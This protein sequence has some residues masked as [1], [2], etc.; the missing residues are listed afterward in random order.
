MTFQLYFHNCLSTSLWL[1]IPHH[2]E[3]SR[4]ALAVQHTD[5]AGRL[6]C[7][8][9]GETLYSSVSRAGIFYGTIE[10]VSKSGVLKPA[11]GLMKQRFWA[12]RQKDVCRWGGNNRYNRE[13][14]PLSHSV[15]VCLA[16]E[17]GSVHSDLHTPQLWPPAPGAAPAPSKREASLAAPRWLSQERCHCACADPEAAGRHH[18]GHVSPMPGGRSASLWTADVVTAVSV[19]R[20]P[21]SLL[22]WLFTP[23]FLLVL[24][25]Y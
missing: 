11:A 10:P 4:Q 3:H 23:L 8:C 13:H 22:L 24:V 21:M 9:G 6:G 20:P 14:R 19:H 18:G 25:I 1:W 5:M 17:R 12:S 15:A 2:T 7:C 16:A